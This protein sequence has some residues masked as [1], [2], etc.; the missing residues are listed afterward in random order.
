MLRNNYYI[1]L[2]SYLLIFTAC[3]SDS[4]T[5]AD[6]AEIPPISTLFTTIPATYSGIDF[7]NQADYTEEFNV[8]TFRN[9]YNGA[10][11]AM[12]DVNND[13]LV[14]IYFCGNILDNKLYLN[15]GDFKF[16]DITETAGVACPDVWSSGVSMA[17]VNGD[18]WLDIYVCKSGSPDGENRHNELF[19]NNQDGTFTERAKEYG[20]GDTGLSVHA[21]FFDYDKDGDLDCYLLNNSFSPVTGYDLQRSDRN[22]RDSKGGNKLYR[23]DNGKYVDISEEANIYGSAIGFGLGVTIGDVNRDGWQDIFV[24]NDFFEKDYLYINQQDGT[25]KEDLERQIREISMGS[26]GADMADVNNDGYPEIFVTEMLPESNRR[27]KTKTAFENWDKY[28]LNLKNGYYHQFTRN[29]LQLNN[30]NGSFSEIS[31]LAGVHATDWSWGALIADLDND[32]WKDIFVANGIYKDLTDQDYISFYSDPRAVRAKLREG[33]GGILNLIEAIPSERIANYAFQ[34][35]ATNSNLAQ[36]VQFQNKAAEWGLAEPSHSNGSAYADLDNDGDLDLVVNNMNMSPFV[37]RNESDT[38]STNNYLIINLV[39]EGQ[40]KFGL[41]AQVTLFANGKTWYQELAPMR[42]FES[43]VDHRLHFGLGQTEKIDSIVVDWNN[44]T[45]SVLT[46]VP[47][48]QIL[49]IEQNGG[50][51]LLSVKPSEQDK[52]FQEKDDVSFYR[53]TENQFVDFDRDRLIY[54]M[55]SAEGPKMCKGDFDGDGKEDVFIGNASG[56]HGE[57]MLQR[58]NGKWQGLKAT[59]ETFAPD[60]ISED[61]DCACFDADGDGDL[62]LFVASGGNEFP[63]T[64]SALKDR[65]YLNNGRGQFK[66]SKQFFPYESTGCV[67]TADYDGDGDMDIFTGSRLRPFLYGVPMSGNIWQNDGKGNFKNVTQNV[68]PELQ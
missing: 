58:A 17:D 54:H 64:S 37:Y 24:S 5:T 39:G 16:K 47:N 63:T 19:I 32:G 53:H 68:A 34:N 13:G 29:V 41:G 33:D 30:G 8:Y 60:K 1:L 3:Q 4:I 7:V 65:L 12:G 62:D 6:S 51:T 56:K 2:V 11:V 42:G 20:I 57:V 45:R 26:M 36:P 44:Q 50:Q 49:K 25:F 38:L 27:M 22:V 55:L 52:I 35:Q 10:G 46:E 67:A 59:Y 40:N 61:T 23:N 31:R 18:G 21:A 15:Q 66:K 9:F 28:Q 14:D 48:N 43:T